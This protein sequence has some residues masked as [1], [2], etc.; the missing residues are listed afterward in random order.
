L[1]KLI[2]SLIIAIFRS[3]KFPGSKVFFTCLFLINL[4]LSSQ[5]TG[6]DSQFEKNQVLFNKYL[7][8]HHTDSSLKYLKISEQISVSANSEKIKHLYLLQKSHYCLIVDDY[9]G[10]IKNCRPAYSY[11]RQTD[12]AASLLD[13]VYLMGTYF[14]SNSQ[15]D[16]TMIYCNK[17]LPLALKAKNEKIVAVLYLM[18]GRCLTQSGRLDEAADVLRQAL[19][20]SKKTNNNMSIV[21]SLVA[22]AGIYQEVN[23]TFCISFL[24]ECRLYENKVN[25]EIRSSMYTSFGNVYRNIGRYDS[26][27]YFYNQNLNLINKTTDLAPYGGMVGNIGNVYF[28]MGRYEE[29]LQ[30]QFE[31]LEYFKMASDSLDMEIALGTIADIY[32]KKGDSKEALKYY[33][34]A[35][36]MSVRLGFI[37]ELS[38][39]YTGLYQCYEQL[40]NY[41]EAYIAH[42]LFKKFN[43]SIRNVE[44]TKKLTE[45]ELNYRFDTQQKE[46]Q[47]VQ[48]AKDDLTEEKIKHQRLTI[49][50]GFGGGLILVIFLIVSVRNSNI[51]KKINKQLELSHA[52]IN[53]QKNIIEH[54]N[55]EI[56]DSIM[57][58]S[59]IQQGILPDAEEI[60]SL[61]PNSFL[62]YR[63]R[64]IVSGDFYWMKPLKGSNKIGFDEL[65]GVVVADCTGHGVPGAFMSFI[66]STILNQTLN[67]KKVEGPASALNY[68]NEQ[69]PLTLK[70]KIKSGQINDGMEAGICVVNKTNNRIYFAGA[71]LNLIRI[72]DGV[73]TEIKGDKHSIGLNIEQQ[74][75]FTDNEIQLEKGDCIYMFSDGYPDQFGGIKGKKYKYKN[76]L[77]FLKENCH[78]TPDEQLQKLSENFD[79]WKGNLD[80]LDDVLLFGMKV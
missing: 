31:S 79:S 61:L 29:A 54:K 74:K 49:Y 10:L 59:R 37:E 1:K 76:L 73:I 71:N 24:N 14:Y 80:Q 39:N 43:D 60:R 52:E 12:D 7:S 26:A 70:S 23:T 44:T 35:T 56:T 18:K 2:G 45:Q 16:S 27:L 3:M 68:L 11:F 30:K 22:L 40:G 32:L 42:R 38:Y 5:T 13:C 65:I 47:I 64:D 36:A 66:G 19:A 25:K 50:A 4:T 15:Y 72:H 78:L 58:A 55:R 9:V 57:Y 8:L 20:F 51:R 6:L 46:Q 33:K 34:K 69:L 21:Q 63:P 41:K 62:F 75:T 77:N 28:D 67:N 53:Q 48:K 17:Y